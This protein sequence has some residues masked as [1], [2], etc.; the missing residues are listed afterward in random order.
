MFIQ[1]QATNDPDV[2]AFIPGGE[3]LP[4]GPLAFN[5]PE[6]AG[7]SPL[8]MRLFELEEVRSVQLNPDS[9]EVTK[10][11]NAEWLTLKPHLLAAI[12]Q[13]FTTNQPILETRQAGGDGDAADD[14]LGAAELDPETL[15]EP[16]SDQPQHL[17]DQ[18]KE[19]IDTRIH[20]AV[21]Q[22]GGNVAFH[23]FVGGTVN[24]KLEGQ[25]FALLEQINYMLQHYVPEVEAVQDYKDA[26][27][28]PGLQTPTGRTVKDILDN[29]IN[30]AVAAHGGH[31]SLI[32][33]R[34]NRVYLRLEGG[35]QGCGMADVTLKQGVEAEI[36]RN[37]PE[38]EE[39]LDVT[40]HAS[41]S[42]P[43]FQPGKGGGGASPVA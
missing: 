8:A 14:E 26:I 25:A 6:E 10:A 40:D 20:P 2:L 29:R 21:S 37:C 41:G 23:S 11:P 24:L 5:A 22:T 33:V 9:I 30:P 17:I 28:K 3:V 4:D 31:I 36:K 34:G 16:E 19:L 39:I 1:T 42:N 27:P 15:P 43:Y 7:R 13:H 12:M 32:D 38:I 35:C 18:V